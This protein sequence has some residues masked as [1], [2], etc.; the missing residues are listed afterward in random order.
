M[1]ILLLISIETDKV[2]GPAPLDYSHS[3]SSDDCI[4]ALS[5]FLPTFI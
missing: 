1:L 5:S 2:V 3:S 4:I